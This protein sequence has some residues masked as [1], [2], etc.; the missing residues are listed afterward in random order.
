MQLSQQDLR[1]IKRE[2]NKNIV[3]QAK[4]QIEHEFRVFMEQTTE[5]MQNITTIGNLKEDPRNER[6]NTPNQ[7]ENYDRTT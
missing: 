6:E 4:E 7:L 3:S 5:T 2:G 1:A